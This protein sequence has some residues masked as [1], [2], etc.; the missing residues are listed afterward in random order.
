MKLFRELNWPQSERRTKERGELRSTHIGGG[1]TAVLSIKHG[2]LLLGRV[3][4]LDIR[5]EMRLLVC[6][7]GQRGGGERTTEG[8]ELD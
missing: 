6:H 3:D 1:D 5:H 7:D 8:R 4:V 2:R